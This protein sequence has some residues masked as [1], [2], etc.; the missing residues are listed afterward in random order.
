M[1]SFF[2]SARL[3]P[4]L[5]RDAFLSCTQTLRGHAVEAR[6]IFESKASPRREAV[7]L[8]SVSEDHKLTVCLVDDDPSVLKAT[9]RLLSSAGWNTKSFTDP[10]AF[11]RYAEVSRPHL[12]VLDIWMPEMSGLEVQERLRS[13]SP[14]TQVVVLTSKDDPM[15]RSRA[16]A[17]GAAGF[18]LK[19]ASD[20]EFLERI[21]S[22]CEDVDGNGSAEPSQSSA[23]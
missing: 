17:A 2:V 5:A 16:L 8:K 19:P 12:V 23:Q 18:F 11:L 14:C 13:I 7:I 1:T 4:L 9:G 20:D 3:Q 6:Q 22:I 10:T 21:E 15:V